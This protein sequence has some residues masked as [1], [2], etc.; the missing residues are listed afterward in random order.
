MPKLVCLTA[1]FNDRVFEVK[2][3]KATIGRLDDNSLCLP[4]PS[5]S[6]HH[7]EIF[8][9]GDDIIVKDLASTNGTFINETPLA[10][11]KETPLRP[12][13]TLRLGQVELRYETGKRQTDTARPAVKLG[14]TSRVQTV[15][16][17]K[18]SAFAKKTNNTNKI[19]I[20]V[21][22]VLVVIIIAL[23]VIAFSGIG[24]GSATP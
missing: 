3:E 9:K 24:Q 17:T 14:E 19:F 6:S 21:G 4:E 15:V 23:L 7:C 13:Q 20:A 1:G 8:A 12:G 10:P 16:M 18:N 22:A 5:V 11:E 2:P